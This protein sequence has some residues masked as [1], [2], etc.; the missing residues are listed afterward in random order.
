MEHLQLSN[1]SMAEEALN[2]AQS[3]C[4]EDPLL[5]NE[6]GVLAFRKREYVFL[7]S[8]HDNNIITEFRYEKA[9]EFFQQ[10]LSLAKVDQGSEEVWTTTYVNLGTAYRK[11][12]LVNFW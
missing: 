10:A 1:E 7:V 3:M 5:M 6:R 8:W 2:A 12:G 9:V 11:I 4:N